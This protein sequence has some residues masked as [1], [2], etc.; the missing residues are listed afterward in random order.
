[1]AEEKV[2]LNYPLLGN[3]IHRFFG[4]ELNGITWQLLATENRSKEDTFK[5]IAAAQASLYHWLETDSQPINAQRGHW[6]V[7]HIYSHLLLPEGALLHANRCWEITDENQFKDFDLAF[8]YEAMA[9]AYGILGNEDEF[10]KYLELAQKAGEKIENEDDRKVF[11]ST[12]ET[13][14]LIK[15]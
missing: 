13:C 14:K 8:A 4:V 11:D 10:K 9:R 15:Q 12:L 7:S 6:L 5:M 2:K 3:Y 1:M